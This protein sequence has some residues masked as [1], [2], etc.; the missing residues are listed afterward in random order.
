MSLDLRATRSSV[1][2]KSKPGNFDRLN[3]RAIFPSSN[4]FGIP[5][6]ALVTSIPTRLLAYNSQYQLGLAE[7]G[8]AVHF[9]LDDYR[10]ETM[11][12]QPEKSLSRVRKVGMALS[13][14]FSMWL[15]M[16]TVMQMWQV[17]R[18]RWCASWMSQHGI[19]CIPTISWSDAASYAYAFAGVPQS[20]VVAIS[21]VGVGKDSVDGFQRGFDAMMQAI[22]PSKVLVYGRMIKSLEGFDV[23]LY[24]HKWRQ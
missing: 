14:D 22:E 16:P 3:T 6:I 23:Q 13:P 18:S 7:P 17:Y 8:D 15:Q 10:F 20:C 5:D 4:Q 9:F 24:P 11:W 21:T 1:N 19:T 12:S 2:W